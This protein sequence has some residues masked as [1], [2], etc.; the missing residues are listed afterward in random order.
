MASVDIS[1]GT[2][3]M[4]LRLWEN[5]CDNVSRTPGFIFTLMSYNV[6][7]QDLVELHPYLY[8]EH[9]SAALSWPTR[10]KNLFEEISKFKP[11]ILCL[12][13]VQESHIADYYST[14]KILGYDGI[15]KKRTGGQSDG[16]A[17]YYKSDKVEMLDYT[18]AQFYQSD[19]AV[20]N[21]D[22]V[23]IVAKFVPKLHPT[24]E[25]VVA[26]THLLYNP[27]RH[28]VR[29]AQM[30]L[31]MTD[32][33]KM[34]YKNDEGNI[35]YL[36]IILTGDF[37]SPPHSDLYEFITHGNIKYEHLAEPLKTPGDHRKQQL[38]TSSLGITDS[39]QYLRELQQ[40]L[41]ECT[42]IELTKDK[43]DS[44][45]CDK[46]IQNNNKYKKSKSLSHNFGL[47]SVYKHGSGPTAEGTTHQD[48]WLTV[49]YIFYSIKKK[50]KV[51]SDK[52][53]LLSRYRLPSCQELQ[54]V[55]IPNSYIG[56][57]HLSL[58]AKFKLEF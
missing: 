56:S 11:D 7:A 36:P 43:D 48:E 30:H 4:S 54:G 9:D 58:I 16:C 37:N 57:D 34:S 50:D 17:I 5:T 31:L 25:F 40:R 22:N 33:E 29:M 23:G 20:L 47:K 28:D 27:R 41:K 46:S 18:L 1:V 52:L 2:N 39:S 12:Q 13:E 14:L 10:W 38:V 26:T 44:K 8:K 35:H 42:I 49:D 3:I 53:Q 15:F 55:R 51:Q 6:L 45:Q 19:I 32:I 24:R 21:R